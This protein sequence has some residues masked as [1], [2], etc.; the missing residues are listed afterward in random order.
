MTDYTIVFDGGSRGNPGVGYGSYALRRNR[1]GKL[2]KR[3]LRFGEQVTSNEAEYQALIA[4]LEDLIGTIRKA[5]RSPKDFSVEIK[6]DSR[7]IMHQIDGSWKTK[8][9]NLM[10]LRDR[11]EELLADLGPFELTWQPRRESVKL[12]GH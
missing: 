6:G 2:R 9:L 12:L 7:L 5:G 10:P 4:A 8:S 3:R 11:V 1:D